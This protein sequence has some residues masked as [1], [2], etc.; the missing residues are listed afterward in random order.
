MHLL[1]LK[2]TKKLHD[3][4]SALIPDSYRS[5]DPF[6][7]MSH[8]YRT[9]TG[10][11]KFSKGGLYNKTEKRLLIWKKKLKSREM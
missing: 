3:A 10:H 8:Y 1:L 7:P 2:T 6:A 9:R 11:V 5:S 4:A